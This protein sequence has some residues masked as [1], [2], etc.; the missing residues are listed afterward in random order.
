MTPTLWIAIIGTI[1]ALAFT[2]NGLRAV[3][4]GHGHVANAGRLHIIIAAIFVPLLW[5]TIAVIQL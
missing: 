5:L 4:A 3:R 1:L 2:L